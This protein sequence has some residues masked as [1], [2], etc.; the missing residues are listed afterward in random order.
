[1]KSVIVCM[2]TYGD[3]KAMTTFDLVNL[4]LDTPGAVFGMVTGTYLEENRNGVA[5]TFMNSNADYL[6]FIDTDMRFPKYAIKKLME[7]DVDIIGSNYRQRRLPL[8]TARKD[9]HDVPSEDKT[10]I[11]EVE[12]IGMGVCLISRRVFEKMKKPW[13]PR[14]WMEGGFFE[15]EDVGF[16][17]QARDLG[18]KVYVDHDL[19]QEVQHIGEVYLGINTMEKYEYKESAI[20]GWMRANELNFLYERAKTMESVCEIGCWKGRSTHALASACKN[21]TAIDHF[22]GSKDDMTWEMAAK[23]D[24]EAEF[25]K[26]LKDFDVT[27]IKKPSL[28]A[29]KEVGDFDMIFIDA[30][31]D[32]ES[33][34]S[35]LEVWTPKAKKLICGHDYDLGFEGV[36][37]AVNEKF[38]KPDGVIGNIWWKEIN[39]RTI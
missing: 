1:M 38:G 5:E 29:V 8:W 35:D 12:F 31:H 32:Y 19:T 37:K 24:V 30:G 10:G 36:M 39:A 22:Q 18:F 20:D 14:I 21:V 13:F 15:G 17:R 25:R 26:N 2:I 11:E 28:E 34:K 27:L 7:R 33:I 3:V 9:N 4:M 6:A 23:Q 16:C